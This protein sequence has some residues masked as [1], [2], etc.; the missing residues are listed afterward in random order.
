[1]EKQ[2]RYG[3][4]FI[5]QSMEQGATFRSTVPQFPVEDPDYLILAQQRSRFMHYY[6]AESES[7]RRR[8]AAKEMRKDCECELS[9]KKRR[10]NGLR[11]ASLNQI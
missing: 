6:F 3:V 2:N 1:M 9:P 7:H 10:S 5:F 8:G 4:S 11:R